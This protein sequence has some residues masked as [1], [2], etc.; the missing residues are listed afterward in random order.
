MKRRLSDLSILTSLIFSSSALLH[1]LHFLPVTVLSKVQFLKLYQI[2]F[3]K[4]WSF[5]M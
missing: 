1:E 3:D 5:L 4:V 2:A